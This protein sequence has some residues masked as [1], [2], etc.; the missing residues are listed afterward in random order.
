MGMRSR[1]EAHVRDGNGSIGTLNITC[2]KEDWG[3][4]LN[5]VG[6]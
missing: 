2:G 6:E 5:K 4:R 3:T 1:K